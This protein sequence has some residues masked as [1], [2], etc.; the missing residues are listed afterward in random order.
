MSH[1]NLEHVELPCRNQNH[2]SGYLSRQGCGQYSLP[3][4]Q[5]PQIQEPQG[6]AVAGDALAAGFVAHEVAQSRAC[7]GSLLSGSSHIAASAGIPLKGV[8]G[9]RVPLKGF[10]IPF[11][12][13]SCRSKADMII[14]TIWLF[15]QIARSFL[16]LPLLREPYCKIS[17]VIFGNSHN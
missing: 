7:L 9:C 12:L 13:I 17:R 15:L 4:P 16:W 3:L 8:I 2:S 5:G 10:Q 11:G 14:G 6:L 1:Q